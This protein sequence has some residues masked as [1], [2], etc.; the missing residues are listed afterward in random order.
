M[1]SSVAAAPVN[2]KASTSR[3]RKLAD[4]AGNSRGSTPALPPDDS[5]HLASMPVLVPTSI[6][7]FYTTRNHPMNKAAFR[8]TACG[9]SPNSHERCP[10]YRAIPAPPADTVA[11]S[12]E[13]RSPYVYISPDATAITTEKGFRGARANVPLREGAW[14]YEVMIEKGAGDPGTAS[15]QSYPYGGWM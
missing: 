9:P 3:K 10:L 6:P 4:S 2:L 1:A 5:M 7:G 8:Y 13:D 14:Y 12:W 15:N 11:F